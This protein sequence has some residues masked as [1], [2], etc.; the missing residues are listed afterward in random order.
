MSNLSYLSSLE[1]VI[2]ASDKDLRHGIGFLSPDTVTGRK[3]FFRS[4][5][6]KLVILHYLRA[7]LL[8]F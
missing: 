4:F 5:N 1:E 8:V 7:V 2:Q 6:Q 3:L